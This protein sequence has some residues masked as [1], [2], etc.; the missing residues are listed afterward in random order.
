MWNGAAEALKPRPAI[1]IARPARRRTSSLRSAAAISRE[2]DLAGGAVDERR[3]EEQDRGAECAHD[4]VL[5][6]GLERGLAVGVHRTEDVERD[7]EPLEPEEERHQVRR[8]DE[9]DHARPGRGEQRVVLADVVA[10]PVAP[11][12][13]DGQHA[14]ARDDQRRERTEP[15]TGERLGDQRQ[16]VG[17]LV[18]DDRGEDA[19]GDEAGEDD[20]G[21]EDAAHPPGHE[22]AAEQGHARGTEQRQRRRQREPVDLRGRDHGVASVCSR[23][24]DRERALRD[25][26]RPRGEE[27][28][29]PDE[30][31]DDRRARTAARRGESSRTSR[32]RGRVEHGGDQPQHVHRREHDRGGADDGPAPARRRRHRRG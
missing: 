12:D 32:P 19:R 2:A 25:Q 7:R 16:P 13:E 17:G 3:A 28:Q 6:P 23:A 15:V 9:E 30:R 4:Q 11:G 18:E 14:G 26:R 22:H 29:Q 31:H 8:R 20:E 1:S 5:Q 21:A 27:E 24:D 10:P